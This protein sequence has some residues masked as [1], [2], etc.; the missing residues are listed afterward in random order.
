MANSGSQYTS[1]KIHSYPSTD[2]TFDMMQ[3]DT[4]WTA[5]LFALQYHKHSNSSHANTDV[6]CSQF[7]IWSRT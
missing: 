6:C 4:T 7:V 2:T 5:L 3:G 1:F